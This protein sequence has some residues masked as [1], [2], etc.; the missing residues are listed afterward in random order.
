MLPLL[1]HSIVAKRWEHHFSPLTLYS[2]KAGARMNECSG[3]PGAR[4]GVCE[5]MF[6]GALTLAVT[7]VPFGR[8]SEGFN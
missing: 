1:Y 2:T 8:H 5:H 4:T 6:L 7:T 3:A